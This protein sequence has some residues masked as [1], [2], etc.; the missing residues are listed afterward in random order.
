MWQKN[1]IHVTILLMKPLV[2]SKATGRKYWIRRDS[3]STTKNFIYL[4]FF[5]IWRIFVCRIYFSSILKLVSCVFIQILYEYFIRLYTK[6][7][8]YN[9]CTIQIYHNDSCQNYMRLERNILEHERPSTLGHWL[10]SG[11]RKF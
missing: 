2:I 6:F 9:I 7:F 5:K 8:I 10:W 3:T 11:A 1:A 4:A